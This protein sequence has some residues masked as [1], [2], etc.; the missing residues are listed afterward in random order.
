MIKERKRNWQLD[1][2]RKE[3]GNEQERGR[4]RE[5]EIGRRGK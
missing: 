5:R 2:E 1:E 3:I 4:Y